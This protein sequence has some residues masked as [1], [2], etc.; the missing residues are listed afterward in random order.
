MKETEFSAFLDGFNRLAKLDLDLG[1]AGDPEQALARL[2]SY[3]THIAVGPEIRDSVTHQI[4]LLTFVNITARFALG[5]VTVSGVEEAPLLAPWRGENLLAAVRELGGKPGAPVAGRPLAIIGSMEALE[6]EEAFQLTF[7]GWRGG[8]VPSGKARLRETGVIAPA[9]VLAAAIGAAETFAMLRGESGAGR[10][11]K[12]LSIWRPDG[13]ENWLGEVSDGP[14]LAALPTNLWVLGLGH[15][16]QAF[17]WALAMC[18]YADTSAVILALQDTDTITGSTASTSILTLPGMRG[19]KTR[20]VAKALERLGFT[21]ALVE[22]PFDD[23]FQRRPDDPSVL[24][25]GVDNA[26]AR[27]QLEAPGF[28]FIVEA[29]IGRTANDFRS[30][31]LHTFPARRKAAELW[32]AAPLE[33]QPGLDDAPGYRR[34][35]ERGVDQCGLT[36]LA[37]TAVGA[38]FVGTIAAVLMLGQVLRLLHGD[39]PDAVVDLDLR[40]LDACR[41]VPNDR[42]PL[43][44]PG[45]QTPAR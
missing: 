31:R 33:V 8:I 11:A 22:R 12:G 4:A 39:A 42:A 13:D 10:C 3:S 37:G 19:R 2:H 45:F 32:T 18:P 38:P 20:C 44:N 28:A 7:E 35:R 15:L 24:I 1:E 41:A 23:R 9:A 29:G 5:G 14:L 40:A 34:L 21:T 36:R 6:G 27:N 25:C 26:L 17:L 16:G 43:Y 30:V